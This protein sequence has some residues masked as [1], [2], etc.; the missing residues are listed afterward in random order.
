MLS[1]GTEASDFDVDFDTSDFDINNMLFDSAALA[2]LE[3]EDLVSGQNENGK[4]N[5]INNNITVINHSNQIN[6]MPLLLPIQ[7]QQQSQM[8]ST[9][10]YPSQSLPLTPPD[11]SNTQS[12][13]AQQPRILKL[14][15]RQTIASITSQNTERYKTS[16]DALRQLIQNQQMFPTKQYN[17]KLLDEP[18]CGKKS[19]SLTIVSPHQQQQLVQHLAT[20]PTIRLVT[21]TNSSSASSMTLTP[22]D[23]PMDE[24]SSSS[25]NTTT[26]AYSYQLNRTNSNASTSAGRFASMPI[27]PV[28]AVPLIPLG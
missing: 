15:P 1:N 18:S 27:I 22:A 19:P 9:M 28:E 6:S 3:S 23:S 13:A 11:S 4:S 17:M 20:A 26:G 25:N 7:H 5:Q 10:F 16:Y 24:S 2:S 14:D 12:S 8:P 21:T